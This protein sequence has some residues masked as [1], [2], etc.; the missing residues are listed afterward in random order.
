MNND[1]MTHAGLA[2][3]DT[4]LHG[5]EAEQLV[6]RAVEEVQRSSRDRQRE[7]MVIANLD[8]KFRPG[9]CTLSRFVKINS[10]CGRREGLDSQRHHKRQ[11][12]TASGYGTH[13]VRFERLVS[14]IT[15]VPQSRNKSHPQ[16]LW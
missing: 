1:G 12:G 8:W 9:R 15:S 16:I 7:G 2:V 4:K 6:A 10:R 3:V 5:H 14:D 13:V 11:M